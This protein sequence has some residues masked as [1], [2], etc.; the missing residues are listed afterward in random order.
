MRVILVEDNALNRELVQDLLEDDGHQVT[1][2]LSG[3]EFRALLAGGPPPDLILMDILLPDVSGVSLVEE[4]R[5]GAW[6]EVPVVAVTAQATAGD[7]ARFHAA[8]FDDIVVKPI[9]TR[10]FVPR[11]EHLVK[12]GRQRRSWSVISPSS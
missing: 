1:V 8:G 4:V 12:E 3:A 9:D 2:A 6:A 11:L 10:S 7:A 5:S